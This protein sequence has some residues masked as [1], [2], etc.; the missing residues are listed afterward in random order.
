MARDR[1]NEQALRGMGWTVIRF[2][3]KEIISNTD[4]CVKTIDELV[5]QERYFVEDF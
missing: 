2:W 1:E 3:S 4:K 5:Q